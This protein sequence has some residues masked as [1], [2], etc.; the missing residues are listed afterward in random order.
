MINEVMGWS[1]PSQDFALV[2][3]VI[4]VDLFV[5]SDLLSLQALSVFDRRCFTT[6]FL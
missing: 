1:R 5:S 6:L 4:I 2:C 3:L